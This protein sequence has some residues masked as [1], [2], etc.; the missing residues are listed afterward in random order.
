MA[1][2]NYI[3]IPEPCSQN[4]HEMSVAE[5]GRF[6]NSCQKNVFDFTNASNREIAT[7]FK[8]NRSVCGRFNVS[9]LDRELIVPKEK[10]S[11]WMIAATGVISFIG[12]GSNAV[13]AQG[14]IKIEQTDT[15]KQADKNN[16][17]KEKDAVEVSGT[18]YDEENIPLPGT[19][20]LIKGTIN[21]TQ[22]DFDGNYKI[23]AKE[24]DILV[25]SFIGFKTQEVIVIQN[26]K[27]ITLTLSV[28]MVQDIEVL[29]GGAFFKKRTFF[30]RIF[31]SIG[32]I[33]R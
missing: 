20:I 28:E 2:N 31:Q 16:T 17:L 10:S 3:T 4:W 5:K 33:F 24:G 26:S 14:E 21:G 23:K 29:V 25:Y 30:G 8:N 7:A 11:A 12:L 13:Y 27:N 19:S 18:I 9:Q 22:T 15:K 1:K 6:C 32:N